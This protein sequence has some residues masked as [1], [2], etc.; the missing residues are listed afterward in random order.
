[1]H[2]SFLLFQG[3]KFINMASAD[4]RRLFWTRHINVSV[5]KGYPE[6]S[7]PLQWSLFFSCRFSGQAIRC[8]FLRIKQQKH[9][10]VFLLPPE[11]YEKESR[12]HWKLHKLILIVKKASPEAT[13]SMKIVEKLEHIGIITFK[14]STNLGLG[15]PKEDARSD[16]PRLVS[17][18]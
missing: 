5:T 9:F 4:A 14:G 11:N 6:S 13:Q 8:S 18:C 7:S 2:A 12:V 15:L 16:D 1:M 10:A 3:R 17:T